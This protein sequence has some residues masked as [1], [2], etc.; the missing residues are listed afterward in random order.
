MASISTTGTLFF[1]SSEV[2]RVGVEAFD[3]QGRPLGPLPIARGDLHHLEVSPDGRQLVYVAVR[4]GQG[5]IWVHDFA[6]GANRAVTTSPEYNEQPTW[7]PDSRELMFRTGSMD[8]AT[9]L[10]ARADGESVARTQPLGPDAARSKVQGVGAWLS[11]GW[12]IGSFRNAD[13]T[14]GLAVIGLGADGTVEPLPEAVAVDP[15]GPWYSRPAGAIAYV[16][17]ALGA[18]QGFV[19]SVDVRPDGV[20]LGSDRQRL[21]VEGASSMRW[22]QDGLELYAVAPDSGLWAVPVARRDGAIRFGVAKKLF[23]GSFLDDDFDVADNGERFLFRVDPA[24]AHQSLSVV[25]D[26]PARVAL[27][28]R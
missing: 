17:E 7:S 5:D 4:E 18:P 26:W 11:E 20:R 19:V 25:L 15:R 13:G 8:L 21:P 27:V 14:S 23:D 10:R 24:A 1:A 2:G 16:S 28:G 9:I 6:T 3:R 12:G 22:R